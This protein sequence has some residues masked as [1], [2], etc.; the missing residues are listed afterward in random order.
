VDV[1]DIAKRA[2]SSRAA[3]AVIRR[4]VR[5]L[6]RGG[7][8]VETVADRWRVTGAPTVPLHGTS[9]RM[10]GRSDDQVL[11]A[12]YYGLDWEVAETRL[13]ALLA[14]DAV[15][16]MDLGANTGV[17]SLMS[18]RVSPH[19]RVIAVEPGPANAERLRANLQL[20]GDDRVTT[21]EAAV[22]CSQGTLEL[23]V[24]ADGGIS[25]VA[26]PVDAFSRAHWGIDYTT[27]TVAQTTVDQ[28]VTDHDL[29]QVC[30]IKL[31][32]ECFELQALEG[33]KETLTTFAP[34]VLAEVFDYEVFTGSRP[35]LRGRI[36]A[37]NS[38]QV[39]ALMAGHGYTFFAVG[40]GGV[41]R[42]QT[43]RG[44]PDGRSNYL[45]VKDPPEERY[46]PYTDEA[47]IRRL[48]GSATTAD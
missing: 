18:T 47:A 24:P 32:V 33:A 46:I 1:I 13:F 20:N 40:E 16:V 28:L 35:E 22:G 27:V 9:F 2:R 17:Y 11:D 45:F 41:L 31:D 34:V 19:A 21:V 29:D 12:L 30:L 26:S 10:L 5:A 44:M 39:E 8:A 23:T 7:Q 15:V 6:L 43:L 36:P 3:N 14:R 38:E 42:V 37:D 48:M 25:D 4:G